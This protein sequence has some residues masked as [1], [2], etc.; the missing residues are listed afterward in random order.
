MPV[1]LYE[2]FLGGCVKHKIRYISVHFLVGQE[3][4]MLD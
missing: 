1:I 2:E 3:V 4:I